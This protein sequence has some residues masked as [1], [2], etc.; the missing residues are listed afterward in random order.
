[1]NS[2]T[3]KILIC[4]LL[5]IVI[6]AGGWFGR[7]AYKKVTERRLV[8]QARQYLDKQD[9]ANTGL[10]LRRALQINPMSAVAS[11]LMAD[12]LEEGGVPGA[13]S[14]RI[15]AAQLEPAHPERRLAWARSA[16]AFQDMTSAKAALDG[17][18][19]KDKTTAE[20][21]K[22]EAALAWSSK[23]SEEAERHYT[24]ALRLEPTNA[25]I[26]M[27]LATIK[28]SSTNA[29]VAAVGRSTLEG[30]TTNAELR[31]PALRLLETEA[32]S[33]KSFAT[34]LTYAGKILE[35]PEPAIGDRIGY[36]QIARAA[37]SPD[38]DSC[39]SDL[40]RGAATN[41]T[42]AFAVGQWMVGAESPTNAL[43]WL[44]SLPAPIQTNQ[45]VPVLIAN[46]L[47]DLNDWNGL[48]A[49]MGPQDWRELNFY[50]FALESLAR[51]Q[52]K[53][54]GA[55]KAAWQKSERLATQRLDRLS[56]LAQL[57]RTWGWKAEWLHV[58][59][60]I[61][62]E[63]PDEKWASGLL[64]A[65]Y[66]QDGN[67]RALAELL[68]KC[69]AA[70]P[71][72]PMLKNDLANVFLLRKSDL[73]KAHRMARE[74]Y[75]SAPDNPYYAS[76]YAYS[77][78]LQAKL[79]EATKVFGGLKTDSLHIPSVAVYYGIVQARSGHKDLAKDALQL[80]SKATLLP[81]EKE[82]VRLAQAQL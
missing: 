37:Q 70:N 59:S 75:D 27:N 4:A 34:A 11:G 29:A 80:A 8:A 67:T 36:L 9:W 33:R 13:L 7:K 68:S 28:L 1:M 64:L 61:T 62:T 17:L 24:E 5:M 55:A 30:M 79:D 78:L 41:A 58:L 44:Q 74:I 49:W 65:Q 40:K 54:D 66:H 43:H 19:Q 53:Q 51:S 73:E 35:S 45:M 69:Y 2:L 20:Y 50:R 71:A 52:L 25:T 18:N 77:L 57:S 21:H 3:R 31:V 10:C 32:I 14:W 22:L 76:T 16:I 6:A 56:R 39:L 23:N 82:L 46:C 26:V 63:F 48:L 42:Q 47:G 60:K 38:F 12:F 72:D 81:E 15:R